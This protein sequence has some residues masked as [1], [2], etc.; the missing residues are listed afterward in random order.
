MWV[1]FYCRKSDPSRTPAQLQG[2]DPV[3]VPGTPRG[4]G[5]FNRCPVVLTSANSPQRGNLDSGVSVSLFFLFFPL[6]LE[7]PARSSGGPAAPRSSSSSSSSVVAR[8]GKRERFR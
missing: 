7:A 6:L 4:G 5:D 2:P 3:P 1:Y 8:I